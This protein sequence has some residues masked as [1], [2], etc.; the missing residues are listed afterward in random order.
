MKQISTI[1][2]SLL[3]LMGVS[4]ETYAQSNQY[5]HLDGEDDSVIL[6][7]ASQYLVGAEGFTM[8]GWFYT[9]ELVYGQGMLD[10]RGA[11]EDEFYVIMLADG[12]LEC[13][14]LPNGEFYEIVTADFAILPE[15]WQHIAFVFTGEMIEL[16][17]DG[18]RRRPQPAGGT[19]DDPTVDFSIGE[20]V[21]TC[22][23]FHFGGGV[24]EVSLWSKALNQEEI[25]DMMENELKG[26]EDGLEL[27]YKFNQGVPG[28]DNT[29]I[30]EVIS[31]VGAP[32][33]NARISNVALTGMTSNFVGE[34]DLGFQAI[35]FP[36]VD[37]VLISSEPIEI[38]AEA[39]SDL[40][41]SFSVLSGPATVEGNTITLTGEAGEVVVVASQFGDDTFEPAE[42]VLQTFQVLDP[43]KI[44]P[45]AELRN[46][47]EGTVDVPELSPI[48][49]A[50]I[51]SIDYPELFNINKLYFQIGDEIV[52]AKDWGNG[53]YTA[54]WTP[55]VY[56]E[57]QVVIVAQNN[58]EAESVNIKTINIAD[59]AEDIEAI[60]IQGMVLDGSVSVGEV[61][62]E[63]PAY[64]GAYDQIMATLDVNC[65]PDGCDPWDRVVQVEAKGHNGEWIEIIRYITSYGIACDHTIDLTDF[66]SVLQGKVTFRITYVTFAEGFSFNLRFDY[67]AGAPAFKYSQVQELWEKTYEFGDYAN[68]QPVEMLTVDHPENAESS[69]LKLVS[70]GHGWHGN[71]AR[72]NTANAAEFYE[73]THNILVNG[74]PTFEQHN[75]LN[76]S[77][78]PDGCNNQNGSWQFDRAGWCPGAIAPWFEYDMT[79][80]ISENP[81]DLNYR[82][83][84]DYVDRCHPNHPDCET[85]T[86]PQCD[87]NDGFN[88][89]LIVASS[90]I[91]FANQPLGVVNEVVD[92]IEEYMIN[93]FQLYPNPTTGMTTL[94]IEKTYQQATVEVFDHVGKLVF[95]K[96]IG[97]VAAGNQL[98]LNLKS[99]TKGVYLVSVLTEQGKGVQ[100]LIIE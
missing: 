49:L 58:Y 97:Y 96:A 52:E 57:H 29:S 94:T 91:S 1:F 8:A 53:H 16:Y 38:T 47:L 100:K 22:C 12:K 28:E 74:E 65:S 10:F 70:T 67:R 25:A 78:N 26:D 63:L 23:D 66:M 77:P 41:V 87:C 64:L 75:W 85:N 72:N 51:A 6:E 93:S 69:K 55:P 13:R 34:L 54:W 73:A 46:P 3:F 71:E 80:Y 92:N 45:K 15:Q 60:A 43:E 59:T 30:K 82:F 99:L 17:I 50:T 18:R 35:T 81:I 40:P 79:D 19:F 98:E 44:V 48:Q 20:S 89:H 5:L 27:Y 37:N 90:L 83:F 95:D 21:I 76:C 36:L 42:N 61:E 86:P 4:L 7:D 2:I 68:L 24:D 31:E 39:S 33:R 56:G 9:D 14:W 32:E 62:A 88:P 84:E 11:S